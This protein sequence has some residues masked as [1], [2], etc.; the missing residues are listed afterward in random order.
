[1]LHLSQFLGVHTL[2]AGTGCPVPIA[3]A[4]FLAIFYG[5]TVQD[6]LLWKVLAPF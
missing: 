5:W 2:H 1:M 3:C 6:S 4:S